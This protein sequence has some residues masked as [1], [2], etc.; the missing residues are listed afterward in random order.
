MQTFK[1]I[2]LKAYSVSD[3]N[4]NT[5][6]VKRGKEYITSGVDSAPAIGP[7]PLKDHVVVFSNFW[8]HVPIDVFGGE[9][10]FTKA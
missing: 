7:K 2:C 9:V 5:A 3:E 6:S 8:F 1:R 4:G 10:E